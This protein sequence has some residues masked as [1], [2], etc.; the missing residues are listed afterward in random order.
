MRNI[1][2]APVDEIRM[3]CVP[4]G[5]GRRLDGL[6]VGMGRFWVRWGAGF[7]YQGQIG[8]FGGRKKRKRGSWW[9]VHGKI[10]NTGG[11]NET[12]KIFDLR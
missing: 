12:A 10:I 1:S 2:A 11:P 3:G 5:A 4:R 8:L 7:E 6:V 9:R